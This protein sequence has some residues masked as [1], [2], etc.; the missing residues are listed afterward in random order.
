ME[1][2]TAAQREK[3]LENG[4]SYKNDPSFDPVPVV[5]LFTPWTDCTWLLTD[6]D[7]DDNDIAAGLCDL[8]FHEPELGC[9]RLSEIKSIRGPAGL[10]VER[11]VHF[12]AKKSIS[13]YAQEARAA[14]AIRA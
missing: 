2:L 12:V 5:K 11:D 6:L 13:E 4:R 1:L 9:V 3:M 8:G 14:G 7:V 10:R